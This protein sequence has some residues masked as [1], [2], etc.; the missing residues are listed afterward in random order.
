VGFSLRQ[1]GFFVLQVPSGP[2]T[3][4]PGGSPSFPRCDAGTGPYCSAGIVHEIEDVEAALARAGRI[5]GP[6]P[7]LLQVE[8]LGE[9]RPAMKRARRGS[10][11]LVEM[12]HAQRTCSEPIRTPGGSCGVARRG[13]GGDRCAGT[14]WSRKRSASSS[15]WRTLTQKTPRACVARGP[16]VRTIGRRDRDNH[17]GLNVAAIVLDLVET[18][19]A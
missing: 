2:R 10:P 15:P 12:S 19:T 4:A 9:G 5:A 14:S 8:D 17:A 16:V 13:R 11:S 3:S 7:Q 18:D 6:A 1:R